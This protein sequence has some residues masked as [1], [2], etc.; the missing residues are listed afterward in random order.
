MKISLDKN[1]ITKE[2]YNF[3]ISNMILSKKSKFTYN[4]CIKDLNTI[5]DIVD[6]EIENTLKKSLIRLRDDG[7]LDILG[8]NYKVICIKL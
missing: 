3:I 7:F 8:E 1:S 2:D 6:N 5:F 4:D